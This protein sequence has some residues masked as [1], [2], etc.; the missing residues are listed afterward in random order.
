MEKQ[1]EEI[2]ALIKEGR[3]KTFGVHETEEGK[4][5]VLEM[6]VEIGFGKERNSIIVYFN[7]YT[8]TFEHA[9]YGVVKIPSKDIAE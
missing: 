5:E 8:L 1:Y 6:E 2:I 4:T 9:D 3:I 7:G